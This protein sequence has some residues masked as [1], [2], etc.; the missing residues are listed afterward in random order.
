MGQKRMMEYAR[1]IR[2]RQLQDAID[3]VESLARLKS[4]AILKLLRRVLRECAERHRLDPARCYIHEA[5]PQYGHV[6]KTIRRHT[7]GRYGI[8]KAPRHK[9]EIRIREITMEEAFHKLYIVNK[10][11]KSLC[12]DMRL[13]L[14]ENRVHTQ[15]VK[16]WAPYLCAHSRF[17]HRKELK[18][19][20]STRQFDYY[21]ARREWIQR[22][23]ANL[24]RSSEEMR[25]ARGLPPLPLIE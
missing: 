21:K 3:W 6:V 15:M 1:L 10:P 16:E 7:R 19:V 13:A 11:P 23:K 2:G 9:F 24:L 14:Y 8:N 18:W 5:N 20:D 4:E 22:Y 17:F 12:S 25:E